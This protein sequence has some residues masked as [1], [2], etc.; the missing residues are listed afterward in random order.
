MDRDKLIELIRQG[1]YG[2]FITHENANVEECLA[3]TA[4]YIIANGIGD[5]TAEKHRADVAEEA[6][7]LSCKDAKSCSSTC[8]KIDCHAI[9]CGSVKCQN[10]LSNYYKQ[11]AKK[12]IKEK[13]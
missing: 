4:D 2:Y 7:S 10:L 8:E 9:K 5:I 6:L 1:G 3:N 12:R 13:V 11:K